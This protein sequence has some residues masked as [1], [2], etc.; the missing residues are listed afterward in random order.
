MKKGEQGL[1]GHTYNIHPQVKT[2]AIDMYTHIIMWKDFYE[3]DL[4]KHKLQLNDYIFPT[5]GTS[6]IL[7]HPKQPIMGSVIQ[8]KITKMAEAA[9]ISGAKHFTT[10]CF[11]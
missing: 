4:L 8:K 10:H 3:T 7:V 1:N 6:G 9:G 2:P 11:H 5:L